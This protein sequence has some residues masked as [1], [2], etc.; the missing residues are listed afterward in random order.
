MSSPIGG[1]TLFA[2]AITSL[3]G[4]VALAALYAPA[5]LQD[6]SASAGLVTVLAGM[7]FLFPLLVWLRY[8][9]HVA[10]PGGLYGY[11][12]AAAGRPVALIQAG[13][14][15]VSYLLYLLYTSAY[16][17]YDVLP[18]VLPDIRPYRPMVEVALP[19][20]L[21]GVVLAGRGIALLVTGVLAGAQL[22]LVA[23]LAAVTVG[24]DAPLGSFGAH[25]P[26]GALASGVGHVSLLYVCGSLPLFFG[27]E[28]ARPAVTM[29]RGLPA[30][31]GV[32]ALA[33]VLAVFPLAANPAF[34]RAPV[35][36]ASVAEV[37]AGH[38]VAIAVGL[39]VAASVVGVMLVEY[40]ALSRLLHAV[41]GISTRVLIRWLA[42]ALVVAGP[43]SLINPQAFYDNLI[44]PSLVALWASQL[45]A[46]AVYPRFAARH[47]G[48]RVSDVVLTIGACAIVAF[49]LY[50]TIVYPAVT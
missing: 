47:G 1:W 28:L 32:V 15:T 49:G 6:A 13:V 10:G 8:A 37:F 9:R 2:I 48:L 44:T 19:V 18:T 50:T 40:L 36:G 39:G 46:I 16:I 25:V 21:A 20:A 17:G 34:I 45:I 38:P 31:Y 43:V 41:T 5:A 7:V 42:A 12:L 26:I 24:H 22:V 11:V 27:G 14:W 35:P 4:P 33:V 29:R 23:V 3:G 30:A